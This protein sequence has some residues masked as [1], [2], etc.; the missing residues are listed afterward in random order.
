VSEET[1][2]VGEAESEQAL[3]GAGRCPHCG[4]SVEPGGSFCIHCG[5]SLADSPSEA[6]EADVEG[7][8]EASTEVVPAPAPTLVKPPETRPAPTE[9]ALRLP[10]PPYGEDA[11]EE[12]RN[13]K[14][15][16]IAAGVV[17]LLLAIALALAIVAWQIESPSVPTKRSR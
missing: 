13:W 1:T 15:W 12:R 17:A 11:P 2:N 8:A 6:D 3:A 5:Q 10:M 16:A 9:T 7:G 14:P 4:A